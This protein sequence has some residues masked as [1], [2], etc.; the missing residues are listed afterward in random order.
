MMVMVSGGFDPLHVGHLRM[1]RHAAAW[2]RVA[3]ALNSDAWLV[4]KK[5]Y[6]FMP[7]AERAEII[8]AIPQ[9]AIAC[10]F[11]DAD[12]TVCDALRRLRPHYFANGG[13]RV[14][15]ESREHALC[16]ELGIQELWGVGGAKVQSSS[17]MVRRAR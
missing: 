13:D 3:V 15:P 5:G 4:R 12:G 11:D 9:V 14:E 6:A 16:V 7:W 8:E 17:D 1:I 10:A 2:G